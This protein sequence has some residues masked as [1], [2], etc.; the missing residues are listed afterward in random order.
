MNLSKASQRR[1]I[2]ATIIGGIVEWYELYL[3]VYWAPIISKL[4]FG[5]DSAYT[6][7]L[8]TLS[9]FF[10]GFLA[11]PVGGLW[12]GHIGDKQGRRTAFY[13]SIFLMTIPSLAMGFVDNW[14]GLM[15]PVFFCIL[16]IFQGLAAGGELPGAMCYL[17]EC[18][19]PERR[20]YVCSFTFFGPQ[21]GVILA[22]LECYFLEKHLSAESLENWGW[23][24]SF[25]IGGLLG[26]LGIVVRKK[27]K[28]S[29]GF[30]LLETQ[31]KISQKPIFETIARH[32]IDLCLGFF[33]SVFAVIGFYMY[34]IFLGKYFDRIFNISVN[35]NLLVMLFCMSLS[36][37][38]LPLLGKLGDKFQIKKLLLGSAIGV[39]PTSYFFYISATQASV[40]FTTVCVVVLLLFLNIQFALLPRLVS[41]LFPTATRYTGI[42]MSF[43]PCDSIL[44]GAT[45]L[46]ALY[47]AKKIGDISTFVIFI[48]ISAIISI[49][50]LLFIK[51][52][53]LKKINKHET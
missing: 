29:E 42:G 49:F 47:A 35:E 40:F 44:G 41:E 46:M 39:I 51:E 3:Y 30:R 4:F 5:S 21:L 26:L 50:A 16:R 53:Q 37:I 17:A 13:K 20:S 10:V 24:L 19:T 31:G 32:K 25:I 52:R 15:V 27:L 8:K 33:V 14:M 45:P 22:M 48:S 34:S 1:V 9:I 7:S 18:S 43:N 38:T 36:T 28:E 2:N 6:A 23:R 12:F 11:R